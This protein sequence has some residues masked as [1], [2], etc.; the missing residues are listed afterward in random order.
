[1]IIIGGM[2]SVMG[3]L[4]GTAFMVLLPEFMTFAFGGISA[5]AGNQPWMTAGIAYAK[6]ASIGLAIILFLIFEPDGLV[7]RWKMI[8][9]YWK[10]YPFSY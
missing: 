4:M 7:H 3:T 2:G 8:K 9:S 6:Q 5:V 1:M 10:L